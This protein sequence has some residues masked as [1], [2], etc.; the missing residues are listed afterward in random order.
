MAETLNLEALQRVE[1]QL[2]DIENSEIASAKAVLNAKIAAAKEELNVRKK[3]VNELAKMGMAATKAE[4]DARL[5]ADLNST[6]SLFSEFEND[7][8]LKKDSDGRKRSLEILHCDSVPD[9]VEK[10]TGFERELLDAGDF[11]PVFYKNSYLVAY[12]DNDDIIY[13]PFSG[14]VYLA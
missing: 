11:V 4:Q 14:S 13:D 2:H 10:C 9:I 1:K 3:I 6:V 8:I 5:K 12:D 7:S